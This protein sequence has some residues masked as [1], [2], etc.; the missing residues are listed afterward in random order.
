MQLSFRFQ[1]GGI[2]QKRRGDSYRK[3]ATCQDNSAK[4]VGPLCW[5]SVS[6]ISKREGGGG[7]IEGVAE[8][9]KKG[10]LVSRERKKGGKK[11]RH[12]K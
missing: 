6:A 4:R 5:L 7:E 3:S 10:G 2:G 11:G 9:G 12:Y 1:P 8:G